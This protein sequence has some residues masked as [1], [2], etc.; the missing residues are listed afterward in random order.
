[1][2][3]KLA[4]TLLATVWATTGLCAERG[5]PSQT[6]ANT[7]HLSAKNT[8]SGKAKGKRKSTARASRLSREGMVA[9][10]PD[11]DVLAQVLASDKRNPLWSGRPSQ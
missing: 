10:D 7:T 5:L 6:A 2:Q 11:A 9:R 8:H 4:V 1:M 3:Y